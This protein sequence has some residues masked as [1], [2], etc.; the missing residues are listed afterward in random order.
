MY[1]TDC[2]AA[3]SLS[4]SSAEIAI[5]QPVYEL[6]KKFQHLSC[7]RHRGASFSSIGRVSISNSRGAVANSAHNWKSWYLRLCRS[8]E[9]IPNINLVA[10]IE[11]HRFRQLVESLFRIAVEA[12]SL[13]NRRCTT[14][15]IIIIIIIDQW[16][17]SIPYSTERV[18]R[19]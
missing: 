13:R 3:S 11:A 5:A 19:F 12:L 2:V 17:R 6:W 7:S 9:K 10:D 15:I 4:L 18:Q 1:S 16:L 8:Y 14:I